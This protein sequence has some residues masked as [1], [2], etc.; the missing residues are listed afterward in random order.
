MTSYCVQFPSPL[1]P[2]RNRAVCATASPHVAY[3]NLY[4]T[5]TASG[6]RQVPGQT[7]A[8][9]TCRGRIDNRDS[10]RNSGD[11][12]PITSYT[13]QAGANARKS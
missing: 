4:R 10:R 7:A 6:I 13:V 8:E 9:K 12:S 11:V 2:N 3:G 5:F 1:C